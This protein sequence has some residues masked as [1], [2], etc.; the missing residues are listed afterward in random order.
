MEKPDNTT[1]L[2]LSGIVYRKRPLNLSFL[3]CHPLL[4]GNRY[5]AILL[6]SIWKIN[7][8]SIL[9]YLKISKRKLLI[10]R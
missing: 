2:P 10:F 6:N 4:V 8:L 7:I 9:S 3:P 1:V 5:L